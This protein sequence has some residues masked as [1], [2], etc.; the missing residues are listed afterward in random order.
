MNP[1][2]VLPLAVAALAGALAATVL[3]SGSIPFVSAEGRPSEAAIMQV[4]TIQRT[5]DTGVFIYDVE[6]KRLMVYTLVEKNELK[7]TAIRNTTWDAKLHEYRNKS[8]DNMD[9]RSLKK[10]L[11]EQDKKDADAA[12]KEA[13]QKKKDEKK[14]G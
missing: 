12:K 10:A 11:E 1:R 2:A 8:D 14:N 4:A 5:N 6:S 3:Q 7:P 13:E 9:V